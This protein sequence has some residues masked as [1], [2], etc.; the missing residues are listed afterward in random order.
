MTIDE[1]RTLLAG[2]PSELPVTFRTDYR[3]NHPVSG[4]VVIQSDAYERDQVVL[5]PYPTAED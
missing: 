1:L 3:E 4:H 2:L 5:T